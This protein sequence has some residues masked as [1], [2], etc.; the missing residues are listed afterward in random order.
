MNMYVLLIDTDGGSNYKV[1]RENGEAVTFES[2]DDAWQGALDD[3]PNMLFT[4]EQLGNCECED[5]GESCPPCSLEGHLRVFIRSE[6]TCGNGTDPEFVDEYLPGEVVRVQVEPTG[7][8]HVYRGDLEN[9]AGN[10]I[11]GLEDALQEVSDETDR[12][13]DEW[14]QMAHAYGHEGDALEQAGKSANHAY[15]RAWKL[16]MEADRLRAISMNLDLATRRQAPL[17]Q[18]E[19]GATAWAGT[20]KHLMNTYLH[21]DKDTDGGV[22]ETQVG[23][24]YV[25]LHYHSIPEC[26]EEQEF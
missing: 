7:H 9:G 26:W 25:C 4:S 11:I 19:D 12:L 21:M 5:G 16:I 14:D 18:G 2:R 3:L 15:A 22:I 6:I 20:L 24:G 13:A 8:Y 1:Y 17:F 10:P 23:S